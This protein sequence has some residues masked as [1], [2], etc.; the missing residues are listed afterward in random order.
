MPTAY[1][2]G[3]K[4]ISNGEDFY[5][6]DTSSYNII[7]MLDCQTDLASCQWKALEQT[8]QRDRTHAVVFLVPDEL[9]DCAD[10]EKS[11]C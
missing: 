7:L 11:M 2:H 4:G 10:E 8:F 6:V 9:T 5:F 1:Y 3:Q